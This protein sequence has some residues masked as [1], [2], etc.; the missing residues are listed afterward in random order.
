MTTE[1]KKGTFV[2]VK[3]T[4]EVEYWLFM[5]DTKEPKLVMAVGMP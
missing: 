1:V 5:D 3:G 2:P 4:P